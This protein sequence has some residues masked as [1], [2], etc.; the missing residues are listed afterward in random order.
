MLFV[1]CREIYVCAGRHSSSRSYSMVLYCCTCM[2]LLQNT[3]YKERDMSILKQF[4]IKLCLFSHV[5]EF[6]PFCSLGILFLF[7]LCVVGLV[8]E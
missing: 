5:R 7:V 4:C 1:Q 6:G 3:V 2:S 8:H